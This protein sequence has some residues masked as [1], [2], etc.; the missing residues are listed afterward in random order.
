MTDMNAV[1]LQLIRNNCSNEEI[2]EKLNIS[3][4]QL[5]NRI[6]SLK[7]EGFNITRLFNYSGSQN[8]I[9]NK[10]KLEGEDFVTINDDLNKKSFRAI[11][12][13]DTHIGHAKYNI[14]YLYL[15]RDYCKKHNINIIFHCGDLLHGDKQYCINPQEQLET[16]LGCYPYEHDLLTFLAFGNHEEVFLKKY[17]INLKTVIEKYRD[18]IIPL[19]Y[20]ECI[21]KALPINDYIVISHI[22]HSFESNGVR[23]SGHSHRFKF[24]AD[25]YNPLINVPTLSDFLHTCDFPGAVDFYIEPCNDKVR[26]MSLYHLAIDKNKVKRISRIEHKSC[27]VNVRK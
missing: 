18:D 27:K 2:C 20:G 11:A 12:I 19:G 21:V 13:A 7:N 8:Y 17:G 26:Y 23:L 6:L 1:L 14:N 15:I 25:D 3:K 10:N 5:K 22:N 16:F 4:F 24:C 9:F